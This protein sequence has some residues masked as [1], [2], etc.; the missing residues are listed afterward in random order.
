[1]SLGMPILLR[2]YGVIQNSDPDKKLFVYKTHKEAL[3]LL[4]GILQKIESGEL[5]RNVSKGTQE[6]LSPQTAENRLKELDKT[7]SEWFK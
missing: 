6:F 1:M 3:V 5:N 2:S 4:D 7:F